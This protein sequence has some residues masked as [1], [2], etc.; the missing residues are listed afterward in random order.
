MNRED[1]ESA[2]DYR[3]AA[4]WHE[5]KADALADLRDELDAD[6]VDQTRLAGLYEEVTTSPLQ[7]WNIVTAFI[8]VEDD[9]AVVTDESKLARGWWSPEIVDDCD[10][11]ITL[12][13]NPGAPADRFVELAQRELTELIEEGRENAV[14]ARSE[15]E[16]LA[17][18][19]GE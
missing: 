14:Q 10:A 13:V 7:L 8:D 6:P 4:Q 11:M 3:E 1:A 19:D 18:S 15:V 17:E 2:A 16:A 12:D 9:E 5:T